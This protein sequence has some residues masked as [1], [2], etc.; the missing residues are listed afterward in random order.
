MKLAVVGTKEFT[1]YS[2]LS[3]IL[4]KITNI[5]LIISGR[6]PG[7]DKLA[8]KYAIDHKINLLEFPPNY[9]KFGN[10]AKHNRDKQIVD[11][12]DAI[13]A[14]WDGICE[15]TRFTLDYGTIKEKKITIINL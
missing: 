12:C 15:G 9:A 3:K 1:D 4:H 10:K 6:A 11:H 2:L 13:I 7:T 8:A 14:F 5:S